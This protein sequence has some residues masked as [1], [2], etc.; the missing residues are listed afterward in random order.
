MARQEGEEVAGRAHQHQV[1]HGAV[2]VPAHTAQEGDNLA[3]IL[4][5][6]LKQLFVLSTSRII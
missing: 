3:K 2:A 5:T 6:V 4:T 1:G